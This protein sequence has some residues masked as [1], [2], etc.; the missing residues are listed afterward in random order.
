MNMSLLVFGASGFF[1]GF[2]FI[3]SLIPSK[4]ERKQRITQKTKENF[5]RRV[6]GYEQYLTSKCIKW[7]EDMDSAILAL[8]A[9]ESFTAAIVFY[10][11][12]VYPSLSSSK[13]HVEKLCLENGVNT[14]N[15]LKLGHTSVLSSS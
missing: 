14:E 10:M 12:K 4:E 11:H 9:R 13:R 7:Q 6:S 1:I 3:K 8:A 15:Y 5:E 2:I